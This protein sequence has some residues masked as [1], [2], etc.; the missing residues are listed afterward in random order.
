[1]FARKKRENNGNPFKVADDRGQLGHLQKDLV[2]PLWHVVPH[3]P[4]AH[5]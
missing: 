3:V 2:A 1:M 4:V 5:G